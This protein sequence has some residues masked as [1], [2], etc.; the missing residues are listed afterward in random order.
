MRVHASA[1]IL[2]LSGEDGDGAHPESQGREARVSG[3]RVKVGVFLAK[4]RGTFDQN[5]GIFTREVS[6]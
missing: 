4:N 5:S 6:T 3:S 2:S 1:A